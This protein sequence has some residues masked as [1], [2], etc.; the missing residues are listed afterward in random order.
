MSCGCIASCGI[1]EGKKLEI[2]LDVKGCNFN[3]RL[4]WGYKLRHEAQPIVKNVEEVIRN[5]VCRYEKVRFLKRRGYRMYAL[6]FTGNEPSLQWDHVVGV[7]KAVAKIDIFEKVIIETNG[8]LFAERSKLLEKL[9]EI[10]GIRVDIDV[11]FKGVNPKQFKYI[12]GMPERYFYKQIE[13]FVKLFEYVREN[14]LD[15]IRVNPVLGI[16][17]EP[18]YFYR[19]RVLSVEIIFPWGEK[20]DFY[21]YDEVFR[22]EVLSR[23]KLRYDEAPFREYYGINK[24][25]ARE[26]IATV[27]R[28]KRYEHKLPSDVVRGS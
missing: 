11:S 23:A 12:S 6:R 9:K 19:G 5:I 13:G 25:R 21:D 8:V 27:Y 10:R 18:R 24:E 3:C 2:V 17:H 14:K 4:C 28:G 26:I 1:L 16:N 15:N 20:M 7:M 22:R